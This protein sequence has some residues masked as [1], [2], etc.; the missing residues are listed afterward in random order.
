MLKIKAN[1]GVLISV[2][3]NLL[4]EEV[5]ELQSDSEIVWAEINMT[6]A[7]KIIV[8]SYYRSPNDTGYALDQ[9]NTSLDRINKNSKSTVILGG[10]FNLDHINWSIPSTTPG[11]PDI[12]SHEQLLDI[13]NDHSLE[14]MVTKPTRGDRT[15]DLIFTN[16]PSSVNK[17]ETMPP[18]G[19][20]DHGIVY[21]EFSLTL[22]RKKKPTRKS[23]NIIKQTGST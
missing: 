7:R 2:S 6:N 4:S 22:K 1:G 20:A 9:L 17:V 11:K 12:K 14:Q 19:N 8:D 21:A 18:I 16:S 13:M 10:D 23:I 3:T 5:N 15:L